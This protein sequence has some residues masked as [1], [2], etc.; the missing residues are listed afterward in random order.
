MRFSVDPSRAPEPE[1]RNREKPAAYALRS[2]RF[3]AEEVA[4][5][6]RSGFIISA[7]TIVVIGTHILGKPSDDAEARAML[8]RLSGRWH[9]VLS[10]VC[11]LDRSTQ[12]MSSTVS[13]TRVH[14]RRL[15]S[16]EIDWYLATGEHADK[17]GA[18]GAQ[19][20]ASLF[21][22]RIDG[23]FFNVVGFP[24]AAF[25]RLC[26]RSGI[27]LHSELNSKELSPEVR[28]E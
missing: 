12:R 1:R 21:I 6:H 19:G 3:K 23:C 27:L 14:F 2:A 22:D 17:A 7:D 20:R 24:V 8:T 25:H 11:L 18:Y 16:A 26:R 5:R 15:S 28:P 4:S 10:G 9:E 13:R